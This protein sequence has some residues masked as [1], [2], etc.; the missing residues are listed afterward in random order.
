MSLATIT[1]AIIGGIEN[2]INSLESEV[3]LPVYTSSTLPAS[4][5]TGESV[6]S[7]DDTSIKTWNGSAW[8]SVTLS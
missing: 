8:I 1:G 3:K 6:Y 2:R 4:P 7:S 5:A